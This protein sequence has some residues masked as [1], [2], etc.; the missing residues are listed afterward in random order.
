M[1]V[2][3]RRALFASALA[4]GLGLPALAQPSDFA[5]VV[6]PALD[7]VFVLGIEKAD[8]T[9]VDVGTGWTIAPDRLATNAH[10]AEALMEAVPGERV[11]AR[12]GWSDRNELVLDTG[13]M[14]IHPAYGPWN[15]R[16]GRMK[17]RTAGSIKDFEMIAVADVAV[18]E[19]VAGDAGTPLKLANV[20]SPSGEPALSEPVVYVG[21][22]MENISGFPTVHAVPGY[23]TAK[24]DFFFTRRPWAE[25]YLIH[26][27]GPVVGGASGSPMLNA[28]GEVIGIISAAEHLA[29][30]DGS[31]RA[32]FGFGYGQRVDLAV[33]LL[34]DSYIANQQARNQRWLERCTDLFIAPEDLMHELE[35]L[36]AGEAG[37][38]Q[39]AMNLVTRNSETMKPGGDPQRTRIVLEPGY[40]YGFIAVAHDGTDIDGIVTPTDDD[41]KELG[42]DRSLDYY[43][44]VWVG[45]VETSTPVYFTIRAAED[46]I[47]DTPIDLRVV[48]YDADLLPEPTDEALA[49]GV[50]EVFH[51]ETFE[52]PDP[53][54]AFH[55]WTF[56]LSPD[57]SYLFTAISADFLD[58]NLRLV[59]DGATVGE[60][61]LA[62][63]VPVVSYQPTTPGQCAIT[64]LL[65]PGITPGS[66]VS[67]TAKRTRLSGGEPAPVASTGSVWEAME[68]LYT[69]WFVSAGETTEV[70]HEETFDLAPG[71]PTQHEFTLTQPAGTKVFFF[72]FAP[73]LSDIDMEVLADGTVIA[74]D[75]QIDHYPGLALAPEPAARTLTVRV[76]KNAAEAPITGIGFRMLLVH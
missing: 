72:A 70:A 74:T 69:P 22:P 36:A 32:S 14:L 29:I 50:E 63:S 5:G 60:D 76:T 56:D 31:A 6:E 71:N 48:R 64:L 49:A 2:L 38:D 33:E 73:D 46:P 16:L 10:V 44:M 68:A 11:V 21:F 53:A 26:Y 75:A 58:I 24:T 41:A 35:L 61:M 9:F 55:T 30:N 3:I 43:P 40:R 67:F 1:V 59:T 7:S 18:L 65:P 23:V 37:V 19:V 15:K 8:G 52:V 28:R 25:S 17:V 39:A 66:R 20:N 42:A 47:Q 45:P 54:P 4:G 57:Y 51:E 13:K 34:D 27:S 62:D 12:R